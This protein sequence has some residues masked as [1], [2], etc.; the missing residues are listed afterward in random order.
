M[1]PASK[2]ALLLTA[3][4]LPI[5]AVL[6]SFAFTDEPRAPQVPARVEVRTTGG[7][8]PPG[9]GAAEPSPGQAPDN[10]TAPRN[11]PGPG[12]T[13]GPGDLPPPPP[14]DEDDADDRFDDDQHDD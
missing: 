12:S 2:V 10:T 13:T 6:V 1:Q 3:L 14:A 8:A 11:T 7:T 9:E 4:A 5:G